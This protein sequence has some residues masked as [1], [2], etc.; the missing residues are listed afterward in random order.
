[1][2]LSESEQPFGEESSISD[3]RLRLLFTCCHP[4]LA[5]EAQVALTLR[6]LAGLK[7]GEL[8]RAFLVQEETM[9]KRLVRAKAKIRH[10]AI[11]FRVPPDHLL[12]ERLSAV[13]G[14]LYLLFNEG[15]G[16]SEGSELVR[17]DLVAEAVRLS[18]LLIDLMPDEPEAL[19]LA[20]L[21]LLQDSRRSAR[22]DLSGELVPL[23]EQD[24]SCW[25]R[26]EIAKGLALLERALRRGR[27]GPY[28]IQAAI[29]ACHAGAS[30][31][32]A[33]DWYQIA[34]LYTTLAQMVP[35]PVVELNRAIAVA[36][37]V[38]PATGLDLVERLE[39]DRTLSAYHL[40]PAA[41]ADLL[42]RLGRYDEAAIAYR[43]AIALVRT[44]PERRYLER[45]LLEVSPM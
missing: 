34:A 16:A 22:V 25:N 45:R 11:P 4:A 24:R 21:V 30:T 12:A 3:D 9:A 33:T 17:V 35:S 27:P 26:E 7:T 29:A 38:G 40:V 2:T 44:E 1:V 28:Q 13:L 14:V 43:E 19:G 36:M 18:L 20:A 15:Y 31:P 5:V 23:E 37:A 10:A 41:R 39:A 32:E 8:A 42:R 6:T